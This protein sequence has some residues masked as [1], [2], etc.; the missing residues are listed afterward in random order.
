MY[1][2]LSITHTQE[3]GRKYIHILSMLDGGITDDFFSKFAT[4]NFFVFPKLYTMK[5]KWKWKSLSHVRLFA[6]PEL[7]RPEHWSR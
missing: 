1:L 4:F 5:E 2:Y 7:S 6:T 3:T